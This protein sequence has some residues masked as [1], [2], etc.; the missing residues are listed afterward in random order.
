M[1][2]LTNESAVLPVTVAD[3]EAY[4]QGTD[5]G[6]YQTALQSAGEYFVTTTGI[7]LLPRQWFGMLERYDYGTGLAPIDRTPSVWIELPRWPIASVES[8]TLDGVAVTPLLNTSVK[9]AR[10]AVGRSQK[11]E[12]ELTAGGAVTDERIKTAILMLAGYIVEHRGACDLSEAA[13]KSGAAM[14]LDQLKLQRVI[15]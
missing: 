12:I 5:D 15:V 4:L 8:L 10:I 1:Q 14:L 11:I 9:P 6:F 2:L 3:L 13:S 7:E